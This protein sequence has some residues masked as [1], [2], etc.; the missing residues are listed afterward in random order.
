MT[1]PLSRAE[2]KRL[3]AAGKITP[4][5]PRFFARSRDYEHKSLDKRRLKA[6]PAVKSAG[7]TGPETGKPGQEARPVTS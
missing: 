7:K 3:I 6:R 4:P 2:R 1:R 5:D